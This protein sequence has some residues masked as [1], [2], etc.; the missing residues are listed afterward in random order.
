MMSTVFGA[1][2]EL[3]LAEENDDAAVRELFGSARIA[4]FAVLPPATRDQLLEL[5][6]R[7]Q[8]RH[9][10]DA[11]PQ[12]VHEVIEID[13]VTAGRM[14]AGRMITSASA[15]G[16]RLVDI[17]IAAAHQGRG[18]GTSVLRELCARADRAGQRI[19]LTVWPQNGGARRL[20]ER[21]GFVAGEE[22]SGYLAMSRTP[23]AVS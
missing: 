22:T 11:F 13:A 15:A 19:D 17:T 23:E 5:Q 14:F 4:E 7:A 12:A 2:V 16:I 18:V 21:L 10:A 6:Y 1:R 8:S 20:Y 9:Y 3:R